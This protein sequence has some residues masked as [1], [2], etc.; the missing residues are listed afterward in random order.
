MIIRYV[1]AAEAKQ[2]SNVLIIRTARSITDKIRSLRVM[3]VI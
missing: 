3:R 2:L 1:Q